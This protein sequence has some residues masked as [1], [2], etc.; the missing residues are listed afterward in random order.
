M[1]G[2]IVDVNPQCWV[3]RLDSEDVMISTGPT[4]GPVGTRIVMHTTKALR[5]CAEVAWLMAWAIVTGHCWA[6]PPLSGQREPFRSIAL[7]TAEHY[8]PGGHA[9]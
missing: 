3:V 1:A 2:T 9:A 7:A 6:E 5:F 4:L 8:R